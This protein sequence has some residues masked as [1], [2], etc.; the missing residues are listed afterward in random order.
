MSQSSVFFDSSW[1]QGKVLS[2]S[3]L[4]NSKCATSI[5]LAD[6][7]KATGNDFSVGYES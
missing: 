7:A 4:T 5:I 3:V 1:K 2:P 6:L